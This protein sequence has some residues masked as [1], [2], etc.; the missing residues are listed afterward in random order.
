VSNVCASSGPRRLSCARIDQIAKFCHE[1]P[2]KNRQELGATPVDTAVS[3]HSNE[4]PG[5]FA[6]PFY[7]RA[8][9]RRRISGVLAIAN[10]LAIANNILGGWNE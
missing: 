3:A 6:G 10:K 1:N 8:R 5:D 7:K 2:V 4:W 9:V